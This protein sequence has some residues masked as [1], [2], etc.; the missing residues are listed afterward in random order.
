MS[1]TTREAPQAP[2]RKFNKLPCL[3]GRNH[4]SVE[5]REQAPECTQIPSWVQSPSV[6]TY[7][8]G[9]EPVWLQTDHHAKVIYLPQ[10]SP[11]PG[12]FAPL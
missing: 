7:L 6:V 2:A 11:F 3:S 1:S 10:D 5:S 8:V 4:P 9:A 12:P